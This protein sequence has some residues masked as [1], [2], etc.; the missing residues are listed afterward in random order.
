MQGRVATMEV[1]LTQRMIIGQV[2]EAGND[3]FVLLG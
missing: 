2:V 3:Y 1:W